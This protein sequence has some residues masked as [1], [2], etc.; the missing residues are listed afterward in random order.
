MRRQR[1]QNKVATG[2]FILPAALLISAICWTVIVTLLPGTGTEGPNWPLWLKE[3]SN[4]LPQGIFPSLL[5]FILYVLTTFFLINLNNIFAIIR[6]RTSIQSFLFL[7]LATAFPQL[8]DE[9]P[10]LLVGLS[11]LTAFY[12]LFGSYRQEKSSGALFNTFAFAGIAS[13]FVPQSLLLVPLLWIGAASFQ[14]LNLKSLL[15]SIIGFILP[16]WILLSCTVLTGSTHTFF[17]QLFDE[18]RLFRP[19]GYGFESWMVFPFGFLFLLFAASAFHYFFNGYEDKIRT[20]AYLYFLILFGAC[21]F[22]GIGLQPYLLTAFCPLLLI[23][24]S[25]L[26]GHLFALT[27]NKLSNA[28][29]VISLI[30][31][32]VMFV[33]HIWMLL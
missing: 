8:Y 21:L 14:S 28:F 7:L 29:F 19:V 30:G 27:S 25:M 15:A 2:R 17:H 3:A 22:V 23:I 10:G 24:V 9:L 4:W 20:R 1:F 18:T 26:A 11:F 6:I 13:L 31:I 12:Q 5:G 16:W 32:S 33:Y